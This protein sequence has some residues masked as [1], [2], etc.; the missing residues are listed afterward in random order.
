MGFQTVLRFGTDISLQGVQSITEEG[1]PAQICLQG[2]Q[3]ATQYYAIADLLEDGVRIA[4]SEKVGFQT[5]DCGSM[6]VTY[7]S[8]RRSSCHEHVVIYTYTSTNAPSA[9]ILHAVGPDNFVANYQGIIDS[10]HSTVTFEIDDWDGGVNY[11]VYATLYDLYGEEQQSVVTT[12]TSGTINVISLAVVSQTQTSV[13]LSINKCNDCGF[14]NGWVD[15]WLGTEDPN[16]DPSDFHKYFN[17]TDSAITITGLA[18]GTSYWFKATYTCDDHTTEV[19]SGI[20]SG[21]TAA[22]WASTAFTITNNASSQRTLTL[23]KSTQFTPNDGLYVRRWET[24]KSGASIWSNTDCSG[25]DRTITLNAGQSVE[26]RAKYIHDTGPSNYQD[27]PLFEF[28]NVQGS[29]WEVSGNVGSLLTPNWADGQWTNINQ[30]KN[31]LSNLFTPSSVGLTTA[32][33]MVVPNIPSYGIC[34]Y[35]AFAGQTALVTPPDTSRITVVR[36]YNAGS[37]W[38]RGMF[39]NTFANCTSLATPPNLSGVTTVHER[40]MRTMFANCTSLATLPNLAGITRIYSDG[41][42]EMCSGCTSM[43]GTPVFAALRRVDTHG[44]E[45]MFE[46]TGLTGGA[47][48]SGVTTDGNYAFQQMYTWSTNLATPGALPNIAEPSEGAYANMY[49]SCFSLTAPPRM[50]HITT[51][52]RFVCD[53]MFGGCSSLATAPDLTK[54]VR[55]GYYGCSAMFMSC[56]ALQTGADIRRATGYDTGMIADLYNGCARLTTAYLPSPTDVNQFWSQCEP[57]NWLASVAGSG[58]VIAA[59]QT[60]LDGAPRDSVNGIPSGWTGV[61]QAV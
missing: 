30:T 42:K 32:E 12:L 39:E 36:G 49:N 1:K 26:I 6:S 15:V 5:V 47:D 37:E 13:T 20:V 53:G 18:A 4:Q 8:Y 3:C 19:Y 14:Y 21:T 45:L 7:S 27:T 29:D 55:I 44:M 38:S 35:N 10:A 46:N 59:T 2:L 31:N 48:L 57:T 16:T 11:D 33:H 25:S 58:R 24:R 56:T 51:I 60:M 50:G 9:C 52:G 43:T 28:Q 61:V 17:S 54:V 40:G 22:D 41:C 23:K 34:L